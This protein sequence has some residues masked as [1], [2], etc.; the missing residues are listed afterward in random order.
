MHGLGFQRRPLDFEGRQSL[1]VID[2][3]DEKNDRPDAE[4]DQIKWPIDLE[5]DL[6]KRDWIGLKTA[7]QNRSQTASGG[8]RASGQQHIA[9]KDEQ[10]EVS[11]D[12]F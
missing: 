8:Q 11:V 3:Q 10:G 2:W 5:L 12:A 9:D 1:A 6:F 4:H 7:G